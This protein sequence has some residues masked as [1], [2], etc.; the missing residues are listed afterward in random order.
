VGHACDYVLAS[1]DSAGDPA[2]HRSPAST[3]RPVSVMRIRA[4]SIVLPPPTTRS[5][6]PGRQLGADQLD[7]EVDRE[8][9]GDQDGRAIG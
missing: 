4:T 8:A 7:Q 6:V 9:V 5:A 2:G 1:V 3:F